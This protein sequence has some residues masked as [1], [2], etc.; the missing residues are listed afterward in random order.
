M[1]S[2]QL[3]L[4]PSFSKSLSQKSTMIR[5]RRVLAPANGTGT[6]CQSRVL[7]GGSPFLC[8]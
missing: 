1:L 6:V 5:G 8:G 2:A 3:V 4:F 7:L